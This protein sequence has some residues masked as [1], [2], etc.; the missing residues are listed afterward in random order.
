MRDQMEFHCMYIDDPFV[1]DPA[2][3]IKVGKWMEGAM[4]YAKG[5]EEMAV[6]ESYETVK[7]MLSEH[8]YP[9]AN[10]AGSPYGE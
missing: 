7:R 3:I 1:I 9:N 8:K 5:Q 10:I 4:L 2:D 6:S